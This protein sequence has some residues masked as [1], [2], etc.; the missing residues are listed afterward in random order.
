MTIPDLTAE[1]AAKL[2]DLKGRLATNVP[3]ADI[4][5]F[6]AGGPGGGCVAPVRASLDAW[7]RGPVT[8]AS[9]RYAPSAGGRNG[10][11]DRH[12]R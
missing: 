3:L 8:L 1:L 2:P 6:R 11:A 10:D 7:A 5:W 9:M 12:G 4:T